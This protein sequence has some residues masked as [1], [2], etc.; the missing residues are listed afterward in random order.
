MQA[1]IQTD[2]TSY[3]R[4]VETYARLTGVD[5][6]DAMRESVSI[7]AGQLARRFP[8][9][10][11]KQGKDAIMNDLT[12]IIRTD[13]DTDFLE[14]MA[15]RTNDPRFNPKGDRIPQFHEANRNKPRRRTSSIRTQSK[16]GPAMFSD[17]LATTQRALKAYHKERAQS[18]GKM[19]ARWSYAALLWKGAARLPAWIT[20]H[21][22]K[23][24]VHD[25]MKANGDGFIE[26]VNPTPYA[27]QWRD[28]NAFVVKSQ[29]RMFSNRIRA[30]LRK[31]NAELSRSKA[32]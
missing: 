29:S 17:K 5:L 18:V 31:R 13:M 20:K 26:I 19:K 24:Q 4:Q 32:A 7:M 9:K 1:N 25:H 8:P 10:T 16:V 2:V 28:I 21:P 12:R 27:S 15:E 6:R 22:D 14:G 30:V 3:R 23:G 11:A